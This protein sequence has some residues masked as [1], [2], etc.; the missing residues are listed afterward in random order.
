MAEKFF[1]QAWVDKALEVER[2]AGDE[3]YRRFKDGAAFTHVLA[4]EVTDHPGVVTHI[5][6][7]AGRS[8]VWTATNLFSEDDVWARFTA[9]LEHW[10]AGAEGK[11]KA[12]SLVMGGKIK[13]TKGAMKDLVENAA[14]FDGLVQAFGGV[15]TAW[16]I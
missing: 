16:D 9:D 4:L 12:S 15:D 6:Y 7:V 10:R 13:L 8:E 3:T 1:S 14:A 11:A 2:S 5:R